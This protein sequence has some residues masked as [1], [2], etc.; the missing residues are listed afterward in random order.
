MRKVWGEGGQ[1][2]KWR[3]GLE[4]RRRRDFYKIGNRVSTRAFL[5]PAT[6]ANQKQ[7][8]TSHELKSTDVKMPSQCHS[9]GFWHSRDVRVLVPGFYNPNVFF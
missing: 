3:E 1:R 4:K 5:E 7:L 2:K 6:L 8:L 9:V